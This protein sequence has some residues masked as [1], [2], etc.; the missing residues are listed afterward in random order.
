[1]K[2]EDLHYTAKDDLVDE[3]TWDIEKWREENPMD[4][5]LALYILQQANAP[6][7]VSELFKTIYKVTRLYVPEVLYKYYSLS[8]DENLN[9]KKLKTLS[10]GKVYLSDAK[11]FNDPF[12]GKSFF[13]KAEQLADIERLKTHGGKIIDD[14]TRFVKI[15]SFTANGAQSM[16]MWSHYANNHEGFCVSYSVKENID[17]SSGIFPVQ[18]TDD[19][20][21]ITSMMRSQAETICKT[22]DA[23][24]RKGI[25]ITNI[26][27][28]S[29]IYM[30]LLLF[31]VK[32]LFW[33]YEKEFRCVVASN[34]KGVPYIEAKPKEI[35]MGMNCKA[36][37]QQALCEIAD[38][39]DVPIYRMRFDDYS[40]KYELIPRKVTN[41]DD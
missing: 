16:P 36:T 20:L 32:Q 37:N 19:R 27:D 5:F 22:I 40:E 29:L 1:M 30:P 31:N 7:E 4:Y 35:F 10:A 15:A 9:K 33:G 18:Y 3:K 17:L 25:K 41:A 12:D 23:N 2:I 13:Y 8:D 28:G 14:F 34:A 39:Y 21:D 6:E 26:F 38:Y 24:M 11:D